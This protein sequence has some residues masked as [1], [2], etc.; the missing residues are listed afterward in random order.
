MLS[1]DQRP[2]RTAVGRLLTTSRP[3][4]YSCARFFLSSD[5]DHRDLHSFPTR[6]SSD[7]VGRQQLGDETLHRAALRIVE[8]AERS[9]EHTSELQSRQYLVCHLPL[10]KKNEDCHDQKQLHLLYYTN[11]AADDGEASGRGGESPNTM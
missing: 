2:F 8:R 10:E 4:K 3:L 11:H 1:L 5:G 9:E 7:L 6:R